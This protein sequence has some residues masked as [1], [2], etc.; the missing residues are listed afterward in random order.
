MESKE[1]V[2]SP[3]IM[4]GTPVLKA[5]RVPIKNLIEYLEGGESGGCVS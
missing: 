1:I 5:T 4:S 3:E 2:T